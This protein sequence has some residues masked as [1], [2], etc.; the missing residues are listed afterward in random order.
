V[1]GGAATRVAVRIGY[2]AGGTERTGADEGP[3]VLVPGGLD[4]PAAEDV[5]CTLAAATGVP[6]V[7]AG[8]EGSGAWGAA[9][10][11]VIGYDEREIPGRRDAVVSA[12]P[13]PVLVVRS[14]LDERAASRHAPG[15]RPQH[16]APAR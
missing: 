10:L 3:I 14:G 8:A 15:R 7:T 16:V 6:L 4:T 12:A 5:A 13:S 1:L 9:R 2:A 11:V